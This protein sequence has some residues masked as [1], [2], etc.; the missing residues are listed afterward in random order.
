MPK[1]NTNTNP[2]TMAPV[3]TWAF[4]SSKA[5]LV[6]GALFDYITR[7]NQDGALS[8]DCQGWRILK[9]DKQTGLPKPRRCK[10]TDAVLN[11]VPEIMQAWRDGKTFATQEFTV[12]SA[13]VALPAD[14]TTTK[15]PKPKQEFSKIRITRFVEY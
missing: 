11:E 5:P 2:F 12:P 13:P 10:H 3:F 15:K 7:L 4:K 1:I 6:G 8:C 9:K 14:T